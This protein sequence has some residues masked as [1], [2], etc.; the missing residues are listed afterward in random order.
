MQR[1]PRT[2]NI[3]FCREE[4]AARHAAA[5]EEVGSQ[6]FMHLGRVLLREDEVAGEVEND[7]H[8]EHKCE[9]LKH[10]DVVSL[11]SLTRGA[12]IAH[13]ARM[14]AS[15]RGVQI[16]RRRLAPVGTSASAA[17]SRL[18]A[19]LGGAGSPGSGDPLLD[20]RPQL[21][22]GS[23]AA[24]FEHCAEADPADLVMNRKPDHSWCA[25][26]GGHGVLD[27]VV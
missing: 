18:A 8:R 16:P 2:A 7:E 4:S 23:L 24:P 15:T 25:G 20:Q 27:G 17:S 11:A 1:Y 3:R 13:S 19:Q 12:V 9:S 26:Q 5:A 10:A 6:R 14:L 22:R 21:T